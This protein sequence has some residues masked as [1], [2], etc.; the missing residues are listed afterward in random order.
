MIANRLQRQQSGALW[1]L[2]KLKRLRESMPLEQA[3]HII[4]LHTGAVNRDNLPWGPAPSADI[5]WSDP[6]APRSQRFGDVYFSRENGSAESHYVFLQ[7]NDL[8]DRWRETYATADIVEYNGVP[9]VKIGREFL[10]RRK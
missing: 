6:S 8:P 4:D 9:S 2:N 1:Q 5:D 7:G 3:T 10:L